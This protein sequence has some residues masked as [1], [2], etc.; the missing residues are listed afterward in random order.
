MDI[1][2][3]RAFVE[4][5]AMAATREPRPSP[6]S[7]SRRSAVRCRRWSAAIGGRLFHRTGRGVVLTELGERMLPARPRA[8]RGCRCVAGRGAAR[9]RATPRRSDARR[10]AGRLARADCIDRRRNC[11]IAIRHS[12]ARAGGLQRP[13]RGMAGFG[14]GRDRGSNNRYRRGRVANAEPLARAEVHLIHASAITRWR[15]GANWRS[16]RWPKSRWPCRFA[17]TA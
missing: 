15:G 13:G 2:Q 11:A 7:R 14:A 8:G 3:L 17:R 4:V 12:P 9:T 16:G 1:R 5:A 10:G 6:A